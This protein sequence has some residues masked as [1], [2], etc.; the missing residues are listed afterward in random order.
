MMLMWSAV[1]ATGGSQSDFDEWAVFETAARE[2]GAYVDSGA[3]HPPRDARLVETALSGV[4]LS[5]AVTP[6]TYSDTEEQPAAYY[7]LNC[8]NLDEAVSWAHRLPT[9]GCVEVRELLVYDQLV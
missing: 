7:V 6:G 1:D 3:F 4:A 8:A 5:D 9:Y 2:A